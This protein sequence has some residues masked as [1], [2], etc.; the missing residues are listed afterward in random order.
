M[1]IHYSIPVSKNALSEMKKLGQKDIIPYETI[2]KISKRIL[3]K[4]YYFKFE[5]SHVA[6][7][8]RILNLCKYISYRFKKLI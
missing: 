1:R 5:R 4:F 6:F 7:H 3:N 8:C 2:D